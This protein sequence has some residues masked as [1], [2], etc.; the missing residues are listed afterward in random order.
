MRCAGLQRLPVLH[1]RLDR[2]RAVGASEP[3]A[4]GL[5]A[6]NH[7]VLGHLPADVKHSHRL[8]RRLLG[9]LVGC[10]PLP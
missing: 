1:H 7:D 4:L 3:L 5:L 8:S 10:V 2:E 6:A 9:S